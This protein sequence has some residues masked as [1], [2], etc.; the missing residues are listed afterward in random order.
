M[1]LPVL[2]KASWCCWS[3]STVEQ[4][5]LLLFWN[6]VQPTL[7]DIPLE[8][9]QPKKQKYSICIYIYYTITSV[10]QNIYIHVLLDKPYTERHSMIG[11][12]CEAQLRILT[13][14][15]RSSLVQSR[16]WCMSATETISMESCVP[17]RLIRRSHRSSLLH[18]S[19]RLHLTNTSQTLTR[20]WRDGSRSRWDGDKMK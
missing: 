5:I 14:V 4:N 7:I 8:Y 15:L 18:Q 2:Q 16:L 13:R 6:C 1:L 11:S 20:W 19:C 12:S 3:L 9:N 10:P 17:S